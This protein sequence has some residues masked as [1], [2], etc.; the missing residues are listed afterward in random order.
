MDYGYKSE[1][2]GKSYF[3]TRKGLIA[4]YPDSIKDNSCI[5]PVVIT[6]LQVYNNANETGKFID[7]KGVSQKK[8]LTLSY[9]DDILTFSFAAELL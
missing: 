5:P 7:I 4:F 3:G 1:K 6:A 8:E 9:Q 2:T